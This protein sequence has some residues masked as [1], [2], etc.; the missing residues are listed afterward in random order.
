MKSG[1]PAARASFSHSVRMKAQS[2]GSSGFQGA[3]RIMSR[4]AGAIWPSWL[5]KGGR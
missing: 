3:L 1:L 4:T 2:N 5:P